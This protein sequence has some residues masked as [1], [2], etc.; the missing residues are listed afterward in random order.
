[1][2]DQDSCSVPNLNKDEVVD[3][4]MEAPFYPVTSCLQKR[5]RI[6]RVIFTRM[7]AEPRPG[8]WR[9]ASAWPA[10]G[11]SPILGHGSRRRR[12]PG[13][14]QGAQMALRVGRDSYK[15]FPHAS[16]RGA[17]RKNGARD[18][19]WL[20]LLQAERAVARIRG[21]AGIHVKNSQK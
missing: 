7:S 13:R 17:G 15:T 10:A 3:E 14:H 19:A 12:R 6:L 20:W 16:L 21:S 2:C 5:N 9:H 1:M 18:A 4:P 8:R 11:L